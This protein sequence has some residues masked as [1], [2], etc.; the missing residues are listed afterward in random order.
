M[1]RERAKYRELADK[2][3][4]VEDCNPTEVDD[5]GFVG[6]SHR[7]ALK[8]LGNL[9]AAR[10]ERPSQILLRRCQEGC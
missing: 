4:V 3:R 10:Q 1:E 2:C 9:G 8:L 7:V 5:K 6:L